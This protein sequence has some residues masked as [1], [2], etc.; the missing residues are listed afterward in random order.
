MPL[1]KGSPRKAVSANIRRHIPTGHHESCVCGA[2]SRVR[3]ECQWP[4]TDPPRWGHNW[5]P[6]DGLLLYCEHCG[7]FALFE[8]KEIDGEIAS[9]TL[10]ADDA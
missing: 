10:V 4:E 7:Q 8:V 9:V 5:L 2:C 3:Q 1:K 6:V